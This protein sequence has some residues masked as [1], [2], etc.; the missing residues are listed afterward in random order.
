M[1]GIAMY[2]IGL[3]HMHAAASLAHGT[4]VAGVPGILLVTFAT[5]FFVVPLAAVLVLVLGP[6][7]PG[8]REDDQGDSGGGGGPGGPPPPSPGPSRPGSGADWWPEFERQF[9]AYVDHERHVPPVRSRAP[10]R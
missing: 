4:A 3:V 10:Q 6:P 7:E 8:G 2:G 1:H 5:L 9:A